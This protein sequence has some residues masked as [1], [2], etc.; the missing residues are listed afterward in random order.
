MPEIRA[1]LEEAIRAG[2]STLRDYVRPDGELG[3]FAKDWHDREVTTVWQKTWQM[4]CREEHLPALYARLA[5]KQLSPAIRQEDPQAELLLHRNLVNLLVATGAV[6]ATHRVGKGSGRVTVT[7]SPVELLLYLYG[8]QAIAEVTTD[9]DPAD[10]LVLSPVPLM[11]PTFGSPSSLLIKSQSSS[12]PAGLCA[13]STKNW[14]CLNWNIFNL[15]GV[16]ADEGTKVCNAS[17][18]SSISILRQK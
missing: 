17:L 12:S 3:Y 15:P 18:I 4:A 6:D 1:V 7:G 10:V 13:K 16:C 5:E 11:I 9:G 8:R 2:G 14:K